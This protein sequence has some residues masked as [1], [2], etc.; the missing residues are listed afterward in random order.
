M[1]HR[2]A[3]FCVAVA[4]GYGLFVCLVIAHAGRWWGLASLLPGGA[5][6]AWGLAQTPPEPR[7]RH[8][9]GDQGTTRRG[10][11]E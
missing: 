6:F 10:R 8:R 4:F 1:S 5:V 11:V 9:A 7:S 3:M 2:N